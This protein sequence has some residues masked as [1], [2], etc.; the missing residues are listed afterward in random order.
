[1]KRRQFAFAIVSAATLTP[2]F[3]VAQSKT[4]R[5]GIL[6]T[7]DRPTPGGPYDHFFQALATAG[8]VGGRGLVVDWRQAEGDTER[9]SPLAA[10][11]VALEPNVIF[12]S[13][14]PAAVAVMTM[15]KAIPIVFALVHEPLSAGLAETLARPGKNATGL[16][17]MNVDILSK[18]IELLLEVVPSA[19]RIALLYQPEL[20]VNVRQAAL[21]E[22]VI[23]SRNLSA[24]RV[25]IG[26]PETFGPAFDSLARERP[27]A[28]VVIENPSVF[29]HRIEIVRRM[30]ALA[31]PAMYGFQPFALDGGLMSYSI[32]FIDQFRRAAGY[33][34]RI[35]RGARPGELPIE[36]P[37]RF[38][39][40]VN[41][42]TAKELGITIPR[43][44]LLRAD[45]VIE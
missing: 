23:R 7:A 22:Q 11:L 40:T 13:T 14:Q 10:E 24:L 21:A 5:L 32:D 8:W 3:G 4:A 30:A 44:I 41:L 35:L 45:R 28:A 17:S 25:A 2:I 39:L 38:E 20:D 16:A 18:R 33:V 36:Q 12:A 37:R 34:D 31:L 6:A 1:M 42:K 26:R 27:D 9:M 15:T 29:T 19:K 43:L